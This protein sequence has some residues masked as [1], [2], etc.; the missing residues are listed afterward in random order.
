M[1]TTQYF[2]TE[3]SNNIP[4]GSITGSQ[5]AAATITGSNVADKTLSN[6]QIGLANPSSTVITTPVSTTS[7]T[8][9]SNVASISYTPSK[10][11]T[12]KVSGTIIGKNSTAGDGF[13]AQLSANSTIVSSTSMISSAAGQVQIWAVDYIATGLTT[14][15]AYTFSTQI[16]SLT[17]GTATA[18]GTL[19]V[20]ELIA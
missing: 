16:E 15:T 5:I 11:G 6:T 8:A 20:E 10:T 13:V 12:V 7:T 17:G 19:V 1:I 9:F 2:A 4:A 14:G 3:V 18:L